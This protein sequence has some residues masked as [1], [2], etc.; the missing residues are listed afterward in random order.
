MTITADTA[1]S[2]SPVRDHAISVE[3][4]ADVLAIQ[5]ATV[6]RY[7]RSGRLARLAGA[8]SADSVAAYVA[9]RED[10]ITRSRFKPTAA[11]GPDGHIA[12]AAA[13][14]YRAA[15]MARQA[16][17]WKKLAKTVLDHVAD[18]VYGGWDV[19]RK[20]TTKKVRDGK[21][22]DARF[23]QLKEPV[24]MKGVAPSLVVTR[25]A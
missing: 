12:A 15:A 14:Y 16:E 10:N 25:A 22:I 8:V 1:T 5:P 11:Y 3:T 9:T 4:A 23:A 7:L 21:A 2:T 19:A 13:L 18:G 24:P 17:A 6:R 20:P